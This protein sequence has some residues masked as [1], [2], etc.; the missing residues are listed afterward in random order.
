M[1]LGACPN[2]DA[3][4]VLVNSP[5]LANQSRNSKYQGAK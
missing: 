2:A 3:A 1:K 5:N 4:I